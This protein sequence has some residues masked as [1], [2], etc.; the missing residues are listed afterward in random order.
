MLLKGTFS[1]LSVCNWLHCVIPPYLQR[2]FYFSTFLPMR[3]FFLVRFNTKGRLQ[4]KCH[5]R[6]GMQGLSVGNN[7]EYYYSNFKRT[8]G[9]G[10]SISLSRE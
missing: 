6:V 7:G 2:H 10:F 4:V 9:E 1:A 8:E 5:V 3:F